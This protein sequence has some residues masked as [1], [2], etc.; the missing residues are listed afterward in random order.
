MNNN[1]QG[2]G[3]GRQKQHNSRTFLNSVPITGKVISWNEKQFGWIK[4]DQSLN[5]VP[6]SHMRNGKI[7]VHKN[8]LTGNL[9]KLEE[10]QVVRFLLYADDRGL[11]AHQCT[12]ATDN[13]DDSSNFSNNIIPDNIVEPKSVITIYV[14]N[15]FIG[16]II[17][18][19][20][21]QIKEFQSNSGARIDIVTEDE[22]EPDQFKKRD[23]EG[24]R[25]INLTGN[26]EE[27]K[28]VCK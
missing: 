22:P 19:K 28:K 11:G 27:L 18:R 21:A 16:G 5:H 12:L 24:K 25:L 2:G 9:D 17:G 3:F 10:G 23:P 8:D 20:G 26:S 13:G 6:G 7:F 4:T 14:P 1:T 15:M